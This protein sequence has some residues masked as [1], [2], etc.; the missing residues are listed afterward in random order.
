[1]HR[2]ATTTYDLPRG[3]P[4]FVP[5]VSSAYKSLHFRAV[6]LSP[7][8]LLHGGLSPPLTPG[9]HW[10]HLYGQDESPLSLGHL[11]TQ[12]GPFLADSY[13]IG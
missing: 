10:K 6:G 7:T 2:Q 13:P 8:A 3:Y 11:P 12:G 5:Y 9:T 1:M 4:R